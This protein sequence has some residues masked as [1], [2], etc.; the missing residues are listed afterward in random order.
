MQR[1][2][3]NCFSEH[4]TPEFVAAMLERTVCTLSSLVPFSSNVLSKV[5]CHVFV[6]RS[7]LPC[8]VLEALS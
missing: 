1:N 8:M 2:R 3:N 6:D 7:V 5:D 4:E